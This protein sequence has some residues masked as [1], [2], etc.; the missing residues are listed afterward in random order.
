[1]P[2]GLMWIQETAYLCCLSVTQHQGSLATGFHPVVG[3][4]AVV[5]AGAGTETGNNA[6][7]GLGPGSVSLAEARIADGGSCN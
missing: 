7:A 5:G 1:M 6:G 4:V 2:A 3:A